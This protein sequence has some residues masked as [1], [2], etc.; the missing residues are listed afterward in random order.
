MSAFVEKR[1]RGQRQANMLAS[2]KRFQRSSKRRGPADIRGVIGLHRRPAGGENLLRSKNRDNG[3][4]QPNVPASPWWQ[5]CP[6]FACEPTLVPRRSLRHHS[7]S[8]DPRRVQA[9]YSKTVPCWA[10]V[11]L[12]KV[13]LR[14]IPNRESGHVCQFA[15][16][17]VWQ[18]FVNNF[19]RNGPV[20]S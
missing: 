19:T 12:F 16:F 5:V 18:Q 4:I 2:Q 9:D 15:K 17:T 10:G 6:I 11:S 7:C 14:A 13:Q 8:F 1:G 20:F 3:E